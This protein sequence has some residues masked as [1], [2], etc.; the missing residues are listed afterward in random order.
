M[1]FETYKTAEG[2]WN[3]REFKSY[4]DPPSMSSAW[5]ENLKPSP[6]AS[7]STLSTTLRLIGHF[8]G[9][10]LVGKPTAGSD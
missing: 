5:I 10:I 1:T 7:P 4:P 3:G 2:K 6:L 8:D 9:I